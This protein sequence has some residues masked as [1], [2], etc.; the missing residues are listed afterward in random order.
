MTARA[1]YG[2]VP[3]FQLPPAKG[4][5]G[6][7]IQSLGNGYTEWVTGG[8]GGGGVVD[9]VQ[10]GQ[11][12]AVDNTNPAAPV[13]SLDLPAEPSGGKFLT[14]TQTA[15]EYVWTTP[16]G[17]GITEVEGSLY[18]S[19]DNTNIGSPQVILDLPEEAQSG[20]VLTT[21]AEAGVYEWATPP[22]AVYT[23]GLGVAVNDS[24]I[25]LTANGD[26]PY[27]GQVLEY[28]NGSMEWINRT[29]GAIS[30][31]TEGTNIKIT[32]IPV[33][34]SAPT[35][36]VEV[37]GP[38]QANYVVG[39]DDN[40]I[41]MK[42][43]APTSGGLTGITQGPGI[44]VTH[45]DPEAPTVSI[46]LSAGFGI[47]INNAF[48]TVALAPQGT[49]TEGA[50]LSLEA[51]ELTW[52]SPPPCVGRIDAGDNVTLT[53]PLPGIYS[54]AVPIGNTYAAGKFVGG[55]QDGNLT[56]ENIPTADPYTAGLGLA[57][58]SNKFSVFAQGTPQAGDYPAYVD[59]DNLIWTAPITGV[60][61]VS[62]YEY[63][64]IAGDYATPTVGLNIEA[65]GLGTPGQVL[66]ASDTPNALK[67]ATPTT[68]TVT[69]VTGADFIYVSGDENTPTVG[70]NIETPGVGTPGQVL[71]ASDTLNALKWTTP[72]AFQ[73]FNTIPLP[74]WEING[75]Y[76]NITVPVG[77]SIYGG[78]TSGVQ[79]G[80]ICISNVAQDTL[81]VVLSAAIVG[82]NYLSVYCSNLG[83]TMPLPSEKLT[84]AGQ[85]FNTTTNVIYAG[86]WTLWGGSPQVVKW[87]NIDQFD[88][89]PT[90]GDQLT[91][92]MPGF[93]YAA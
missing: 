48:A 52:T 40:G 68:G 73:I 88:Y 30:G 42:W 1:I 72:T 15:G 5:P 26:G 89:P 86:T 38:Y 64:F 49:P 27:N 91:L 32:T 16:G 6:Q 90:A 43:V 23:G 18:I 21:T 29:E 53:V 11:N 87:R 12:I 55:D 3:T 84:V 33:G 56:W 22:G 93:V 63:M 59:A 35:V 14:S 61:S 37:T 70:L 36:S 76:G 58:N 8:G 34:A 71:T 44:L 54:I 50:L 57:L 13:V 69:S 74:F 24:I 19:I 2:G 65:P 81:K 85:C 92:I 41:S 60:L 20:K 45:T 47:A 67:W 51:G 77:P 79:Y 7:V 82:L 4:G 28:Q 25:S 66:T 62:V 78:A 83:G 9:E 46:E 17:G 31:L 39:S 75:T 10:A 80:N